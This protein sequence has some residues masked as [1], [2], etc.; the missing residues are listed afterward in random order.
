MSVLFPSRLI[1]FDTYTYIH[2][3]IH[4]RTQCRYIS[5]TLS[6][7]HHLTNYMQNIISLCRFLPPSPPGRGSRLPILRILIAHRFR[8]P[9]TGDRSAAQQIEPLAFSRLV[10]K[11]T[12]E[13]CAPLATRINKKKERSRGDLDQPV[14]KG[15][16]A[17]SHE[18]D[19]GEDYL[20]GLFFPV[21]ASRD[22]L[23]PSVSLRL[24]SFCSVYDMAQT[25][26]RLVSRSTLRF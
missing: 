5:R 12:L 26:A 2:A 8:S 21:V 17:N 19:V 6:L 25:V 13:R 4:S 23:S 14:H 7:D 20:S 24:V 18:L 15:R 22:Q 16:D 11:Q 9:S 1:H 10:A 3:H